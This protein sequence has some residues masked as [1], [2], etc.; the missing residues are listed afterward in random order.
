MRLLEP[1]LPHG[2][3]RNPSF[4]RFRVPHTL[5]LLAGM[6]IL[7][8]A[9]SFVVPQGAYKR[10]K[11]ANG[12]E[13][14]Q[15]GSY[16]R[17]SDGQPLSPLTIL[18]AVPSGFAQSQAII[19]FTFIVGGTIAVIRA[20]KAI[21]AA[22]GLALAKFGGRRGLLIGGGMAMFAA[23]SSTLGMSEE[24]VPFTAVL[25]ALCLGLRMDAV[26]GVA[27]IMV[28]SAIGYGVAAINPFTVVIAQQV[29]GLPPTSGLGLRL[30]VTVPFLA[31]GIHHVSRYAA[32]VHA[33]PAAIADAGA[34]CTEPG[35]IRQRR[36]H[37]GFPRVS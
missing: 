20:T 4:V 28:G 17:L 31:I 8:W 9:A 19:F 30:P 5:A 6:I 36:S 32:R 10:I 1:C 14:V 18:T 26:T 35:A 24:Y 27:I 2:G 12:R 3:R 15:A 34:Q 16:E 21:D 23:G 11:D 33:D 29:A 7:A 25:V 22:L 37:L 13:V